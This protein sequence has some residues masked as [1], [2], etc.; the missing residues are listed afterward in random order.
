VAPYDSFSILRPNSVC[1]LS[2]RLRTELRVLVSSTGRVTIEAALVRSPRSFHAAGALRRRAGRVAP[3]AGRRQGAGRGRGGGRPG[4]A[5]PAAT[6][7][8]GGVRGSPRVWGEPIV[9]RVSDIGDD[10]EPS[11]AGT[12]LGVFSS[13]TKKS[14]RSTPTFPYEAAASPPRLPIAPRVQPGV[15]ALVRSSLL[16]RSGPLTVTPMLGEECPSLHMIK[17]D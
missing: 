17:I 7:V 2:P 12:N 11:R 3:G 1:R 15:Q 9:V 4:G 6:G 8:T 13:F 5:G 10:P 16:R 14:L